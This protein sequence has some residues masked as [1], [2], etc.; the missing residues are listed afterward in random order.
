[1]KDGRLLLRGVYLPQVVDATVHLGLLARFH[2]RWYGNRRKQP[3]DCNN[4]HD[5]NQRKAV[6][7]AHAGLPSFISCIFFKVPN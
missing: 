5:L 6:P 1:M 3:N 7:S 2:E 4:D